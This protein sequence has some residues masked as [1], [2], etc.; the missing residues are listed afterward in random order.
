MNIEP[1]TRIIIDSMTDDGAVSVLKQTYFEFNG[2]DQV[3]ENHREALVPTQLDRAKEI[4]PEHLYKT[5]KTLWTKEVVDA[6]TAKQKAIE[7][8]FN[9]SMGITE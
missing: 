6:W 5:I 1:K 7:E 9:Q 3:L 8:Q 4:L 2:Q